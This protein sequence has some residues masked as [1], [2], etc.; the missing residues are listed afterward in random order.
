[1]CLLLFHRRR[2]GGLGLGVLVGR[3]P[4]H[5]RELRSG[6]RLGVMW[7]WCCEG[8]DMLERSFEGREVLLALHTLCA[9]R[10]ARGV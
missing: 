3:F 2:R 9:A 8:A 4:R 7:L 5:R 1:M 6:L 10:K